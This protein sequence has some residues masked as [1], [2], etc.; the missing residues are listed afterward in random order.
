MPNLALAPWGRTSSQFVREPPQHRADAATCA[1]GAPRHERQ[2][3]TYG[4]FNGSPDKFASNSSTSD[5][6]GDPGVDQKQAVPCAAVNQLGLF[7]VFLPDEA[8]VGGVIDHPLT[9]HH[10]RLSSEDHV[11]RLARQ[12]SSSMSM[13][14]RDMHLRY[15][16]T[17]LYHPGSRASHARP[18]SNNRAFWLELVGP[19]RFTFSVL[20]TVPIR[21]ECQSPR[22]DLAC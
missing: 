8:V 2:I 9:S 19:D 11:V 22:R 7:A 13:L 4:P 21:T 18:G 10:R 6:F 15:T 5:H 20:R 16:F 14:V 3:V 12:A 1:V 17:L